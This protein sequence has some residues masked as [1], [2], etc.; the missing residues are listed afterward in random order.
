MQPSSLRAEDILPGDHACGVLRPDPRQALTLIEMLVVVVLMGAVATLGIPA[1]VT[2]LDRDPLADS[3]ASLQ[4]AAAQ[5][6]AAA[7]GRGL[8]ARLD[9]NGWTAGR[10]LSPGTDHQEERARSDLTSQVLD[11]RAVI[12][13]WTPAA[14]VEVAWRRQGVPVPFLRWDTQGR[15]DDLTV[16]MQR[17]T[18][19]RTYHLLGLTG[20]WVL[21]ASVP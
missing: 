10:D 13:R 4:E 6:R 3:V 17:G 1:L 11:T 19:S 18:V 16:T 2:S 8:V 21:E 9:A 7:Y 5:T 14:G 15:S 12:A 20:E